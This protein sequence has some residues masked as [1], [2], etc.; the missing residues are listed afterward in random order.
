MNLKSIASIVIL[1]ASAFAGGAQ[2]TP[3]WTITSQGTISDGYDTTGVF[4]KASTNLAGLSYIQTIT[5]SIDPK[6][7]SSVVN[8]MNYIDM[9]GLGSAFTD[10]VTVNGKTVS[11]SLTSTYGEQYIENGISS[12]SGGLDQIYTYNYGVDKASNDVYASTYAY[13]WDANAA[14]VPTLDFTKSMTVAANNSTIY[15]YTG[16]SI[17]GSSNAYFNGTAKTLTVNANAV[18]EPASL[19]LLGLGLLGMTALRRRSSRN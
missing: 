13:T 8:S 1:A 14:F 3:T 19:A 7:Y 17:G 12:R 18:P 10:T 2:A 4:G 11:F 9:Y 5:A 16:F 6:Q 15:S